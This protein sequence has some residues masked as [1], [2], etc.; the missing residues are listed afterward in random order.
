ML[1]SY[2]IFPAL[3]ALALLPLFTAS[4]QRSRPGT[5]GRSAKAEPAAVVVNGQNIPYSRYRAL[6]EDQLSYM[7]RLGQ[8]PVVDQAT[9]DALLMQLVD[10]ELFRQEA[11]RRKVL[12]SREDAIRTILNDPPISS[13]RRSPTSTASS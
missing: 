3:A 2:R 4:A 6:Y 10:A 8:A 12:V 1:R 7:R 13:S 11:V 9:D 5:G